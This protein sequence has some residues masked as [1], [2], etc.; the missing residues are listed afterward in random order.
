M[1]Q[2]TCPGAAHVGG[3]PTLT[4]KPCP[5][6]GA[7]VELFSTD[8]QRTCRCGFVV[9]NDLQSCIQ[10]CR[11]ARECVGDELYEALTNGASRIP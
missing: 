7:E 11:K 2:T 8:S 9:Y 10:W 1:T 3:T 6:C 5:E 4:L